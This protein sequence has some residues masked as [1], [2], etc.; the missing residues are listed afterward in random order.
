M[1][2]SHYISLVKLQNLIS[3]KSVPPF[4]K[5]PFADVLLM[6][7]KD[8]LQSKLSNIHRKTLALESLFNK[9]PVFQA[10]N[11]IKSKLQ[12]WCSPVNF[13]K[14]LRTAFLIEH[15]QWLLMPFTTTF[16]KYY[17]EYL[18][19]ILL[20]LTHPSKR[21]NIFFKADNWKGRSRR[22][23]SFWNWQ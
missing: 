5:Q 14:F 19:A 17:W 1:R 9:V 21:L 11:F 22:V 18:L 4:Q 23:K 15:L 16:R 8:A 2:N 20:T 7:F 6:F 13:A 10:C 3:R 12:Q